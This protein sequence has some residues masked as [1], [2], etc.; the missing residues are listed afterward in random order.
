MDGKSLL[1]LLIPSTAHEDLAEATVDHLDALPEA[2]AY[3]ANWR[4]AVFL[5]YY[6]VDGNMNTQRV[7][8]RHAVMV[9]VCVGC[10]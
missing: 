3:S 10:A 8:A 6:Y 9:C 7:C 1:P 4:D 2:E 5:E